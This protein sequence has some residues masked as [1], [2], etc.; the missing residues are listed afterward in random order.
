M[1]SF[2]G[3]FWVSKHQGT[4]QSS[5]LPTG[6]TISSR[7]SK[8]LDIGETRFFKNS[9]KFLKILAKFYQSVTFRDSI[10][11]KKEFAHFFP[12][13][14]LVFAFNTARGNIHLEFLTVEEAKEVLENWNSNC[15]G[16][17]TTIRKAS[18]P[19]KPLRAVLIRGVPIELSEKIIEEGLETDFP[20]VRA[21][22]FIKKDKTLLGTVKLVFQKEIDFETALK[23]GLFLDNIYYRAQKFVQSGVHIIRC[24]KCQKFGHVSSN[25]RSSAKCGHCAADHSFKDCTDKSNDPLCSNCNGK[26]RSDSNECKF[27]LKQLVT[28]YNARC[29][30]VPAS[31][32]SEIISFDV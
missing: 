27:Y 25:C 14:K 23:E 13:K 3:G 19:E 5:H 24:F 15:F 4:Q 1:T 29:I 26:H 32:Q 28:V 12:L 8:Y 7:F 10:T 11:I 17:N 6:T 31:V 2:C 16:D 20:G 21:K 30:E 9:F 18:H 22:R